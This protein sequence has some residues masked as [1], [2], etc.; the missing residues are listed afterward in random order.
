MLLYHP[1]HF[2]HAQFSRANLKAVK[3]QNQI[4]S[5]LH[6]AS[7]TRLDYDMKTCTFGYEH[8]AGHREYTCVL[9]FNSKLVYAKLCGTANTVLSHRPYTGILSHGFVL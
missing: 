1:H 9:F 8:G 6:M 4:K 7:A 5:V 3:R 2:I